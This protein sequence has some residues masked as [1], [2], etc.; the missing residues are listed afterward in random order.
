MPDCAAQYFADVAECDRIYQENKANCLGVPECIQAAIAQRQ[1]CEDEAYEK[2][3]LC[4]TGGGSMTTDQEAS[5]KAVRSRIALR[6]GPGGC[7]CGGAGGS[8]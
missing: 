5:L 1:Q 7:G 3:L 4:L 8:D 6:R 2:Y